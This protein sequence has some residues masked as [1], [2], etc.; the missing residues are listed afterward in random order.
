MPRATRVADIQSFIDWM[1][2]EKGWRGSSIR[3]LL[4][5][6]STLHKM[7]QEPQFEHTSKVIQL[8]LKGIARHEPAPVKGGTITPAEWL[9]H[10]AGL[11]SRQDKE[12][13][14]CCILL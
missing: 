10:W 6:L 2:F 14:A 4:G 5:G 9:P 8:Q 1:H 12:I 3:S 7:L 13:V 11:M